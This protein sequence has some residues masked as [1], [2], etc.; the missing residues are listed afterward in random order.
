[1]PVPSDTEQAAEEGCG[2]AA[3]G[4]SWPA[5]Y[6]SPTTESNESATPK[7][8]LSAFPVLLISHALSVNLRLNHPVHCLSGAGGHIHFRS[9]VFGFQRAKSAH[10]VQ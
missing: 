7:E 10:I 1:M 2:T 9:R 3:E 4:P 6:N 8:V 5:T